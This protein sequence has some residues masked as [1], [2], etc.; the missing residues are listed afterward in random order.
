MTLPRRAGRW[1][2][3]FV[4]LTAG[5]ALV[6]VV[7]TAIL[8]VVVATAPLAAILDRH[9]TRRRARHLGE[10]AWIDQ[11]TDEQLEAGLARVLAQDTPR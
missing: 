2:A 9:A 8:A 10:L 6:A 4:G 3:G 7:T 5:L 11:L 1:L